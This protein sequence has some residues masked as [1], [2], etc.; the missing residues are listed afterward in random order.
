[1]AAMA[2]SALRQFC[3][4][5]P[6]CSVAAAQN[7]D[8]ELTPGPRFSVAFEAPRDCTVR[9]NDSHGDVILQNANLLAISGTAFAFLEKPRSIETRNAAYRRTTEFVCLSPE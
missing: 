9:R 3:C 4:K 1:M 5:P 7:F 6:L 8:F 2:L